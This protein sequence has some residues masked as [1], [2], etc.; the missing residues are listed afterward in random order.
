[1]LTNIEIF[2]IV[3]VNVW[4]NLIY[5]QHLAETV[6]NSVAWLKLGRVI[7]RPARA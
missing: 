1:M 6:G 2:A 7:V 3:I 4:R 5:L